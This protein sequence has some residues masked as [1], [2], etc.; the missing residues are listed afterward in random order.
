MESYFVIILTYVCIAF[1]VFMFFAGRIQ[2]IL[3]D[4]LMSDNII[5]QKSCASAWPV[6]MRRTQIDTEYLQHLVE[7]CSD[8]HR[9]SLC[10]HSV[11]DKLLSLLQDNL[12]SQTGF[13]EQMRAKL[14]LT[15]LARVSDV[16]KFLVQLAEVDSHVAFLD[17]NY[18]QLANIL[19]RQLPDVT[20]KRK[21][22]AL[23]ASYKYKREIC[24]EL[25]ESL[26]L[27]YESTSLS[28]VKESCLGLLK[29][30]AQA[31]SNSRIHQILSKKA[32]LDNAD[33]HKQKFLRSSPLIDI[34]KRQLKMENDQ[35]Y[36]LLHKANNCKMFL[37]I[38][39]LDGF[40]KVLFNSQ[41]H[42][43]HTFHDSSSFVFFI[44]Q[45]LI[46]GEENATS[47]EALMC[48]NRLIKRGRFKNLKPVLEKILIHSLNSITDPE[49]LVAL[50]ECIF[51]SMPY[52]VY[53]DSELFQ[54]CLKVLE[55]NLYHEC[56]LIR[57]L[58]YAGLAL[59][60]DQF[61]IESI[62]FKERCNDLLDVLSKL[63][64][65]QLTQE[66][67]SD[68]VYIIL[69]LQHVDFGVFRKS[70]E[71]WY[72]ELLISNIFEQLEPCSD[73]EKL[74]FYSLWLQVEEKHRSKFRGIVFLFH[75]SL[76]ISLF[77]SLEQVN[78]ILFIFRQS[79]TIQNFHEMTF[80]DLKM[81]FQCNFKHNWCMSMI[82]HSL[83]NIKD[84]DQTYLECLV[85]TL[86]T[87]FEASFIQKLFDSIEFIDDLNA[88]ES[89]VEFCSH[90]KA[91]KSLKNLM[92]RSVKCSSVSELM[93][94]LQIEDLCDSITS[95]SPNKEEQA[96][97]YGL[98]HDM[99]KKQAPGDSSWSFKQLNEM[100][101]AARQHQ[102][103][104]TLVQNL[105]SLL[106]LIF[107][108]KLSPVK[109]KECLEIFKAPDALKKLNKLIVEN[110]FQ[111]R[112]NIK[113]AGELLQELEE[114][115]DTRSNCQLKDYILTTLPG[116]L[117][118]VKSSTFKS[119]IL[120][121]C[122]IPISQWERKHIS[123]WV[124]NCMNK[125]DEELNI[126][127]AIA[128]VKRAN[129][130]HT[131]FHLTDTQILAC[132]ISLC[133]YSKC[134]WSESTRGRLL[135][136]ATGE[137]KSTIVCILAIVSALKEGGRME[138]DVIT[139]SPVLAQRD[140]VEKARLF[141]MFDLKCSFNNDTMPYIQGKN[142]SYMLQNFLAAKAECTF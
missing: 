13:T 135:Q 8:S 121:F 7:I 90:K 134:S 38:N 50:T 51:L 22:L 92:L 130:W 27:L 62:I 16:D 29:E 43:T 32:D 98:L 106:Q 34:F 69:S 9:Q 105:I 118:Q 3:F 125:I 127:E 68:F 12:R 33:L 2:Q 116:Q 15:E 78:E 70:K 126:V 115:N 66:E 104:R 19:N 6:L 139:S 123:Q 46:T 49:L 25:L 59:A 124:W 87:H 83:K 71:V 54:K 136:V 119:Q 4:G 89:L 30:S 107:F 67:R 39:S 108:L 36:D 122:Q 10:D 81:L 41:S 141:R 77:K 137:G 64:K 80:C 138:V 86:C 95:S 111:Q 11:C 44:E 93:S 45:V 37:G 110:K 65:V 117:R 14:K 40:V 47:K 76:N 74:E 103:R 101:S 120:K 112:E 26:A 97:L 57:V 58:S 102:D 142:N 55:T 109:Y 140:A 91:S 73:T 128:V 79:I 100:V 28:D 85:T 24:G 84:I 129:F 23:L 82:L 21:V 53:I 31:A 63:V 132:L 5:T 88:F 114:D 35:I 61:L 52:L 20:V 1:C 42:A 56:V 18:I 99:L 60:V 133:E 72:R 17:E 96:V 48:Y 113:N 131:G 94:L 75:I